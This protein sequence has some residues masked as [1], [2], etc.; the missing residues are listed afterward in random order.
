[1]VTLDMMAVKMQAFTKVTFKVAF[2]VS[3]ATILIIAVV[4]WKMVMVKI[5]ALVFVL[6]LIRILFQQVDQLRLLL[7]HTLAY[8]LNLVFILNCMRLS[9]F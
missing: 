9:S 5:V 3:G 8:Q 2:K 6:H 4:E 1:M 7:T